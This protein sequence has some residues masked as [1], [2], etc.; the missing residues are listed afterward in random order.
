VVPVGFYGKCR[1]ANIITGSDAVQHE[2]LSGARVPD[3]G[4]G[5]APIFG[6]THGMR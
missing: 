4:S 6:S 1:A 2:R 5:A 3:W